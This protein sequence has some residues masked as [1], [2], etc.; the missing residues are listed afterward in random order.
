MRPRAGILVWLATAVSAC[1][2]ESRPAADSRAA[3]TAQPS[4][5]ADSLVL[6]GPGGITVWFTSGRPARDS[7]GTA[8]LERALE[9]RSDTSRR[10][11]PLLYTLEAPILLDDTSM[12]AVLYSG[13]RAGPAYRVD[14]AT[15][16]PRRISP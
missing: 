9:V 4:V 15:V 2:G 1:G 16:S 13:C 12:Q 11:V 10:G 7:A 5:P 3:T 14:F 8:C 6:S